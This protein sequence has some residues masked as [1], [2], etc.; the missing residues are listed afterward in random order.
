MTTDSTA[1]IT[2]RPF[3]PRDQAA[4]RRLILAG[5]A[6]HFGVIDE[7]MNPDLDDIQ[8]HYVDPGHLVVV[9]ERDGDLVGVGMLIEEAPRTGRL[10]RMSVARNCRGQGLGRHLVA[11]LIAAAR[12]RGYTRL[13]VETNDD[14]PDAIGLYGAGGFVE[15]DRRDGEIHMAMELSSEGW[16]SPKG[17]P[18]H[19]SEKSF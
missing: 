12:A 10:V 15:E 13:L 4:T 18:V 1:T 7:T 11:H 6:D 9:A 5:L 8:R 2:P 16:T 17:H 14:W 3:E 19:P